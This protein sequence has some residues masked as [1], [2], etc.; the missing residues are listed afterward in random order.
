MLRD[1]VVTAL[2]VVAFEVEVI[3]EVLLV[4]VGRVVTV[5]DVEVLLSL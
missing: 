1:D 3:F 2:E 4:T 5:V